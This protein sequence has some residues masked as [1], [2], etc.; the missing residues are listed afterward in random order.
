MYQFTTMKSIIKILKGIKILILSFFKREVKYYTGS[1][2]F[3]VFTRGLLNMEEKVGQVGE[4]G[5]G[6]EV[7]T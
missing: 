7:T 5:E 2:D 1:S 6:D 3:W 4:T